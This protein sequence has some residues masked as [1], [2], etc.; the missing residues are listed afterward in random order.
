MQWTNAKE[1][2]NQKP[3]HQIGKKQLI[4]HTTSEFLTLPVM[5]NSFE[6]KKIKNNK[7]KNAEN[8]N[9]V[10]ARKQV[11]LPH[12]KFYPHESLNLR[13]DHNQ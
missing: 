11:W 10:L 4:Y 5:R 2:S 1:E 8:N 13:E 9:N 3:V 12:Q 6:V 7:N